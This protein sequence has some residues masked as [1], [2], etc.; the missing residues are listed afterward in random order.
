MMQ[1]LSN[2]VVGLS[3]IVLRSG[4]DAEEFERAIEG[5]LRVTG[6]F[7]PNAAAGGVSELNRLAGSNGAAVYTWAIWWSGDPADPSDPGPDIDQVAARYCEACDAMGHVVQ[8]Y[9]SLHTLGIFAQL[10]LATERI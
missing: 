9:G 5:A 10:P 1:E 2:A 4:V 3:T 6:A 7:L 8:P